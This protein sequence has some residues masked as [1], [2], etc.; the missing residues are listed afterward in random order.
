MCTTG[1]RPAYSCTSV[2]VGLVTGLVTP[3]DA[4]R[5]WVNVVF[6]A[7][8]S[9]A[10]TS[11]SPGSS[12]GSSAPRRASRVASAE[13]VRI[14]TRRPALA[15]LAARARF[16]STKSARTLASCDTAGA[17]HRRRVQ[18]RDDDDA[19]VLGVLR[20]PELRDPDLGVEQELR[21]EVAEGDDHGR[22]DEPELRLEEGPARLDLDRLRVAVSRRSALHDVRDV[23]LVAG[24]PDPLDQGRQEP[25]RRG[26]RTGRPARPPRRRVPR[27]RTAGRRGDRLHRTRPGDGSRPAGNDGSPSASRSSASNDGAAEDRVGAHPA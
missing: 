14:L 3:S 11:T 18:R 4:A 27:P 1:S 2:N 24:E 19:V 10:S 20:A 15:G 17:Q 13:R 6:P 25:T 23:H 7:P 26:R 8:R 16:I 9:P 22:F 12:S 5:P 21:R